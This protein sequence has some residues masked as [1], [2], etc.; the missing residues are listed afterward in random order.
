[1]HLPSVRNAGYLRRY[2]PLAFT[3]YAMLAGA[4]TTGLL[5]LASG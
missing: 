5:A 1:M 2:P 3:A 4:L